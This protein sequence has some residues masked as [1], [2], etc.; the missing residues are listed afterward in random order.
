M[1]E[2]VYIYK[3]SNRFSLCFLCVMLLQAYE[4]SDS[5]GQSRVTRVQSVED[6]I[7]ACNTMVMSW[8]A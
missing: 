5:S 2:T 4:M 8:I 3:L 6:A 1:N 7:S